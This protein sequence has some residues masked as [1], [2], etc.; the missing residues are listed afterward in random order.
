MSY[1]HKLGLTEKGA[2]MYCFAKHSIGHMVKWEDVRRKAETKLNM[3]LTRVSIVTAMINKK[4]HWSIV[5]DIFDKIFGR[6]KRDKRNR[7]GTYDQAENRV[8]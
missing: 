8:W 5:A 3:R 7:L 2:C 4:E 1:L 6:G